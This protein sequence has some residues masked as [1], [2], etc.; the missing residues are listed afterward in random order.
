ML[1][2]LLHPLINGDYMFNVKSLVMAVS[3]AAASF[4]V[5]A[6]D[7]AAVEVT[8]GQFTFENTS[9]A[10]SFTDWVSFT[11]IPGGDLIATVSGTSFTKFS[12]TAFDLYDSAKNLITTGAF[13][14]VGTKASLGF[15]IDSL[16]TGNYYLYIA[17]ATTGGTYNGNISISPVPEPESY[18][19]MLAGI[20]LMGFVARRRTK[21]SA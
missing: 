4:S 5:Q 19:M 2:H 13:S 7:Y 8:P 3:F 18:A 12:L 15:V 1:N 17:G 16:A 20:G 14:N 11:A 21:Y 9:P 10:A 6:A